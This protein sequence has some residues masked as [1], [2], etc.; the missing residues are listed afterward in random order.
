[1][2]TFPLA[3]FATQEGAETFGGVSRREL[4][5]FLDTFDFAAERGAEKES[6]ESKVEGEKGHEAEMKVERKEKARSRRRR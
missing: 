3:R 4:K 6:V 2:Y 5:G 1:M